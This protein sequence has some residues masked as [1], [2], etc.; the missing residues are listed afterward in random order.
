MLCLQSFFGDD[1]KAMPRFRSP[2]FSPKP[3]AKIRRDTVPL[4]LSA[5]FATKCCEAMTRAR[6]IR[7]TVSDKRVQP[8]QVGQ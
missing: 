7:L 5:G 3:A 6:R 4:R 2:L 8:C 1:A